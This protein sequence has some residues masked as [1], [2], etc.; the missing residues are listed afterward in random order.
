MTARK[1]TLTGG[2]MWPGFLMT[3]ALYGLGVC[4]GIFWSFFFMM[5]IY[6][7]TAFTFVTE[8]AYAAVIMALGGFIAASG[9]ICFWFG[10]WGGKAMTQIEDVLGGPHEVTPQGM[11]EV[12]N[13]LEGKDKSAHRTAMMFMLVGMLPWTL[14]KSLWYGIWN[15]NKIALFLGVIGFVAGAYLEDKQIATAGFGLFAVAWTIGAGIYIKQMTIDAW[16]T[17]KSPAAFV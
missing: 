14:I 6:V 4:L 9:L 10:V 1:F 8:N 17:A 3:S 16:K 13:S 15:G 2:R 5:M 7:V 12:V 11:Q